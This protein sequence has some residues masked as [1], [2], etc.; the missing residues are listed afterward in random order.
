MKQNSD[1]C[2]LTARAK[3][4]RV[5]RPNIMWFFKTKADAQRRALWPACALLSCEQ[6]SAAGL[7]AL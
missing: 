2:P 6:A 5:A 7:A 1:C 4:W 3:S